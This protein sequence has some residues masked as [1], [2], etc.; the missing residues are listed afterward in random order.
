MNDNGMHYTHAHGLGYGLVQL[1]GGALDLP[2]AVT[3][4]SLGLHQCVQSVCRCHRSLSA[5]SSGTTGRPLPSSTLL[6]T[7]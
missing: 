6:A 3:L 1:Q 2:T 4:A 7:W 5:F